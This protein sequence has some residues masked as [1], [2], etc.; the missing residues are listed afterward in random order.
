MNGVVR[1]REVVGGR[2]LEQCHDEERS[3]FVQFFHFFP[4]LMR[5]RNSSKLKTNVEYIVLTF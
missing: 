2:M 1:R 3:F 5:S 4:E